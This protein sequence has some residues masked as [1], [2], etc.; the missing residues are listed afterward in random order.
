MANEEHLAMLKQGVEV[1]NQWR[2]D[3]KKIVPVFSE[4]NLSKENLCGADLNWAN[5]R[6]TNLSE[7]N[8]SGANLS[9]ANLNEA[10]LRG[11]NLTGANLSGANLN[12]ANFSEANLT[13]ANI[14]ETDLKAA[15]LSDDAYHTRKE[16]KEQNLPDRKTLDKPLFPIPTSSGPIIGRQDL[17]TKL[18]TKIELSSQQTLKGVLLYTD[19]DNILQ[20]YIKQYFQEFHKLSDDWCKIFILEKPSKEWR[21][22]NLSLI[23]RFN[24]KF[25]RKIDKSEAYDIAREFKI[26]I[27]QIPCLILFGEEI[28]SQRLIIPIKQVSLTDLPKYFR[29]LFTM[30]E[31]ILANAANST[32]KSL[33]GA[34][35]F[36]A[37]SHH[38]DEI[39]N[40]LDKHA[41]EIASQKQYLYQ[42]Q[43]II[44]EKLVMEDKSVTNNL[45]KSQ[46]AG[47]IVNAETV[48]SQQIGGSIQNTK[49]QEQKD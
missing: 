37:I 6:G 2:K 15:Y 42:Q 17:L 36:K 22:K 9:R 14:G 7:A 47:G 46:I 26:D 48:T 13:G 31:K 28:Y 27:N 43:I 4:I 41:Q 10:N 38:F 32:T 21:N 44:A 23:E 8:L 39:I 16:K 35:A 19:E 30:L 29:E 40:Y 49:S 1:W 5:F 25:I 45:Q 18:S 20:K 34:S 12:E 24:L 3:N 33:S 11:A